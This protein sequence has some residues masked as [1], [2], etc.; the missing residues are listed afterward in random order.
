MK[1]KGRLTLSNLLFLMFALITIFL[2][3][4]QF[5]EN[6]DKITAWDLDQAERLKQA[7][8]ILEELEENAS[9]R[10]FDPTF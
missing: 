1:M 10:R 3:V 8:R 7:D 9:R 2:G 4:R 5:L 6:Q